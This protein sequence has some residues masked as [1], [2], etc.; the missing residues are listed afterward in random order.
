MYTARHPG[1]F[2]ATASYSGVLDVTAQH[3]RRQFN[4]SSMRRS[5]G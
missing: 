4:R 5:S 2:V 1:M 3:V